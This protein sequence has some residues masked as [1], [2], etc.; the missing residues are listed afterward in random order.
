MPSKRR[1]QNDLRAERDVKHVCLSLVRKPARNLRWFSAVRVCRRHCPVL[2]LSTTVRLRSVVKVAGR[3]NNSSGRRLA[4]R[5]D[6]IARETVMGPNLPGCWPAV[7]PY[8]CMYGLAARV[9]YPHG[10]PRERKHVK[11]STETPWDTM[12]NTLWDFYATWAKIWKL[13]WDIH[14]IPFKI[15]HRMIPFHM[16]FHRDSMESFT[17]F[18]RHEILRGIK[19]E[20][21]F[22][23]MAKKSVQFWCTINFTPSRLVDELYLEL[24]A[25]SRARQ[26][27]VTEPA[28]THKDSQLPQNSSPKQRLIG[29]GTIR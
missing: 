21:V 9:L 5:C 7:Y 29:Y 11:F 27:S 25:V 24:F 17:C 8:F 18:R 19:S 20:L 13:D 10:I 22:C 2:S 1:L 15:F 23:R 6:F 14:G 16:E 12:W 28:E 26:R 4:V 3:G